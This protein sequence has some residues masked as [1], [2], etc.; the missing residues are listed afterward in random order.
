MLLVLRLACR[1]TLTG[2]VLGFK[3]DVSRR[4]DRPGTHESL[5]ISLWCKITPEKLLEAPTGPAQIKFVVPYSRLP[6]TQR[7][8]YQEAN[9]SLNSQPPYLIALE[10]HSRLAMLLFS[11][12]LN[13]TYLSLMACALVFCL[14]VCLCEGILF[15]G[16]GV[17]DSCEL[18]CGCWELNQSPMQERV[19]TTEPS[20]QPYLFF[21]YLQTT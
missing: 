7:W 11:F 13:I 14:H 10:H 20:L 21:R 8:P 19:L 5:F 18:P 9:W 16:T 17:A 15:P 1:Y 3:A 6:P 4:T 2:E 12:F